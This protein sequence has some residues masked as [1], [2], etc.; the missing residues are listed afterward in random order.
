M[1]I[2]KS[3]SKNSTSYSVI[4]DIVRDGKRTTVVVE[5]LGNDEDILKKH[6]A[7]DPEKWAKA[8]AKK[9]SEE[10]DKAN[11]SIVASFSPVKQIKI[12]RD[13]SFNVG[14]LFLE[15]IYYL[16]R[17]DE[18]AKDISNRYSFTYDFNSILSRL[19]FIRIIHPCSK[20]STY[21]FSK[22]LIERANFDKHQ[23][24]RSLEIIAKEKDFIEERLYE[25]SKAVVHR[26]TKILYF[27][28]TNFFFEIEKEDGIKKYG[29][30]KENK[31]NPIVQMGLFMDG[32]GI[33]LSMVI[34][35]GNTNE[36][37]TILPLEKKI[38]KDFDM[39][40]FVVCTD[41]G[42][43]SEENRSFNNKGSRA[44]ITTQSIKKLKKH[45]KEW[46][47]DKK[48]WHLV[49]D[50][51]TYDISKIDEDVFKD[52]V[53]Y[54]ERWIKENDLEQRLIVTFSL[55]YKQYKRSIRNRQVDRVEKK[56]EKPYLL[57]KKRS[58]DPNRFVDVIHCTKE[59]EK[60]KFTSVGLN[61][62]KISKEESFDGFYAVCTNLEADPKDIISINKKR[63]EIEETFKI[64]KSEF[65]TRPVHLSR[66]DRIKA[67]FSTCFYSLLLYR[68]LEKK[69]DEHFTCTQIID[70]LRDMNMTRIEGKGYIPSYTRTSLTDALHETFNFRT[71]YEI[72]SEK[73]MKKLLRSI[74]KRK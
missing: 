74:K 18:I 21:H 9:L 15:R 33:P 55:K 51:K 63:W 1:R 48:G 27:D 31:P 20:L 35:P 42:L 70:T 60:A 58:N 53:F 57:D 14:Y 12:N 64:L 30:S 13:F 16:L 36:Q 34:T 68:I 5:T 23:I 37:K 3:V 52:R 38:L 62:E 2:K 73:N 11:K 71:D 6:P 65:K 46:A 72:I 69:L 7:V 50:S 26:N 39:S 49:N 22:R 29:V 24:Y 56:I 28:C 32:S 41:A 67:H 44:F 40:E 59:G 25:Y 61:K 43:S 66:D 8:Y 19:I 54:K 10:E 4:K 17:I 47:L 45:L